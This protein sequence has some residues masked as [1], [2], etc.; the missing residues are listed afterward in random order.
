M[1]PPILDEGIH[2]DIVKDN[3]SAGLFVPVHLIYPLLGL[4]W[5]P[6]ADLSK[7]DR[8]LHLILAFAH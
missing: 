8:D 6:V 7:S 3:L 5:E 2:S 1:S 4:W